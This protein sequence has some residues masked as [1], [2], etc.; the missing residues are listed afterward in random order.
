MADSLFL[1]KEYQVEGP[2]LVFRYTNKN[3]LVLDYQFD[4]TMIVDNY[5]RGNYLPEEED[6]KELF[7]GRL[8]KIDCEARALRVLEED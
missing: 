6:T 7:K 8:L 2:T 5:L 1:A 4:R 3:K